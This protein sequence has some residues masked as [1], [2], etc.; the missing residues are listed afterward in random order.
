V[1]SG[2]EAFAEDNWQKISIGEVEFMVVKP[3]ARCQVTTIDQKTGAA[4]KEPLKT[5]ATYRKQD[6]KVM[7]GMNLVALST[8]S[9]NLNDPITIIS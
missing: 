1:V 6:G 4:S 2:F 7:F 5:L 9:V 3:C 8:G